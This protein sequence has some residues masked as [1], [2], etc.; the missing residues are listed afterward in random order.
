MRAQGKCAGNVMG[1]DN[2][3]AL[4]LGLETSNQGLLFRVGEGLD[5]IFF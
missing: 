1:A 5:V 3:Y 2:L 4:A